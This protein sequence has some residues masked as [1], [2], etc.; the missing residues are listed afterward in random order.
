[1]LNFLHQPSTNL[2]SIIAISS[3]ITV[4]VNRAIN[5]SLYNCILGTAMISRS[6]N[7]QIISQRISCCTNM[8][9]GAIYIIFY[10]K[11]NN[12]IFQ[13]SKP[14]SNEK[15]ILFSTNTVGL[16]NTALSYILE[17]ITIPL[18]YDVSELPFYL[19]IL[20][21]TQSLMSIESFSILDEGL[22]FYVIFLTNLSTVEC[23]LVTSSLFSTSFV[24][25]SLLIWR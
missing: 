17:F 13:E 8:I 7:I 24:A 2:L 25:T 1:M 4:Q 6:F 23:H 3:A 21:F 5:Y 20:I 11:C 18:L 14:L 16:F 10:C 19:T 9:L 12:S 15:S 22:I